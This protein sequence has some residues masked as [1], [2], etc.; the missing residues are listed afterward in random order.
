MREVPNHLLTK[1]TPGESVNQTREYTEKEEGIL[2]RKNRDPA[3]WRGGSEIQAGQESK[4]RLTPAGPAGK[5]DAGKK[6][7]LPD[8]RDL[9]KLR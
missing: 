1:E 3:F 6:D 2:S 4:T 9:Q 8:V 5:P 7:V